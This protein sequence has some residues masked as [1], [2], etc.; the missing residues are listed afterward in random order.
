MA[1]AISEKDTDFA[2]EPV[3]AEARTAWP[4][5]FFA[6]IGMATALIYMQLTSIIALTYGSKIALLAIAY[7]TLISGVMAWV[8]ASI[9]V[10]TGC[11]TNLL[12]RHILGYR[13]GSV[14]SIGLGVN[15]LLFF[16]LEANIM[17]T[18]ISHVYCCLEQWIV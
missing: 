11:G 14:F 12:A 9:A 16:V 18:S 15:A 10:R 7:S 8:I 5:L 3:P 1:G 13:G 4:P 6:T 2:D 17:A